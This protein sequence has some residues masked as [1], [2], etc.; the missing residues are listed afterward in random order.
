MA[1]SV[2]SLVIPAY[3]EAARICETI[4]EAHDYFRSRGRILEIIVSADGTDGTREAAAEFGRTHQG[5]RVIGSPARRG[6]GCG[7]REGVR[8]ARGDIIGFTDADNKTPIAE[9]DK[10]EPRLRE[11]YDVV[12]GSRALLGAEIERR[13]PM[14][15]RLG[16]RAFGF[17]MHM[18]VGLTD[19]P[20]TQC[21]FKFFRA[22]VARDLFALQ[23]IDGY[24]FDVE[25]LYLA[26]ARGYRMT[27][28]PVRW[29]DDGDS[30]SP[31]V[32]GSI[33]MGRDLLS[34]RWRHRQL[35]PRVAPEPRAAA[36]TRTD[37]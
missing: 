24:M 6:K 32:S 34:I 8:I 17:F 23:Q 2:V 1:S 4:G 16:S 28:V 11:G 35:A 18:C 14:Y 15:R 10:V 36:V 25:V 13:Q 21:G 9:F 12:I 27:Q 20:D 29:R 5:I 7:L 3:N 22:D 26:R 30:R 33:K 19:I 37:A 31:V